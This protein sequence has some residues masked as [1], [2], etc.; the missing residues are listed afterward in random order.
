MDHSPLL[1]F[2]GNQVAKQMTKPKR[3][4]PCPCGSGKKYKSCCIRNSSITW[5]RIERPK[6][7][8]EGWTPGQVR[9]IPG[10]IRFEAVTDVDRKHII[11]KVDSCLSDLD[12][13]FE[14]SGD[15]SH[16]TQL[17]REFVC[18]KA[19]PFTAL[20]VDEKS[21]LD[22]MEKSKSPAAAFLV[23][24][25]YWN[26]IDQYVF[27]Y[28]I[29]MA[30]LLRERILAAFNSFDDYITLAMHARQILE[31]AIN[32]CAN[33]WVLN[34]CWWHLFYGFNK[35]PLSKALVV[36]WTA[37]YEWSVA[38]NCLSAKTRRQL[39]AALGRCESSL[40][41]GYIK[42][43][44]EPTFSRQ[45]AVARLYAERLCVD[46]SDQSTV[47]AIDS[48]RNEY[49]L[50]CHLTHPSPMMFE[51][52]GNDPELSHRDIENGSRLSSV[53][54]IELALRIF[55]RLFLNE[56]VV[57][58]RVQGV[59]DKYIYSRAGESVVDIKKS[60]MNDILDKFK[61]LSYENDDGEKVVIHQLGPHSEG[62]RRVAARY[63]NLSSD[64]Q[65]EVDDFVKQK[66]KEAKRLAKI[67]K[68]NGN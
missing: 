35:E 13:A 55:D 58:L 51:M 10:E 3:N 8:G 29:R 21:M 6:P 46:D 17:I 48:V 12:V 4:D 26:E 15:R 64:D 52:P 16:T 37:L 49:I 42:A 36:Y 28:R 34:A 30:D 23:C 9:E 57:K 50:L 14:S 20:T 1:F 62:A 7:V 67:D 32:A 5:H 44:Y 60:F 68:K 65:S 22:W 40:P 45:L 41:E 43:D 66:L 59:I 18:K 61:D 33:Q 25:V 31:I 11:S 38:I 54:A 2:Y 24:S 39:K 19:Q 47:E 63:D 53:T 56:D 27:Q